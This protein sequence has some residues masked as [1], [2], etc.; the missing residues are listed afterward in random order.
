[1][2]LM[3]WLRLIWRWIGSRRLNASA[4]ARVHFTLGGLLIMVRIGNSPAQ[5]PGPRLSAILASW[6]L[7]QCSVVCQSADVLWLIVKRRSS[8]DLKR[9]PPY[10]KSKH[11]D[12]VN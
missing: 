11:G 10:T 4:V 8:Q 7:R 3:R 6:P 12:A 5:N 2:K 1:M 9:R